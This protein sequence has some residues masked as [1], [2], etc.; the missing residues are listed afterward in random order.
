MP[1]RYMRWLLTAALVL[2][3]AQ[4]VA[5]AVFV[6]GAPLVDQPLTTGLNVVS[7]HG[8]EVVIAMTGEGTGKA[9]VHR[10]ELVLELND[11]RA[12][13][14]KLAGVGVTGV[15]AI[16]VLLMLRR[17]VGEVRDGRPF[18][19]RGA[20][21]IRTV[22]LLVLALPVWQVIH[23]ALWQGLLLSL[24]ADGGAV[25][26]TFATAQAGHENLRLMPEINLGLVFVGLILMV[27][28]EAFRAGVMLQR[29]SDEIV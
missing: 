28:G 23:A 19:P 15:L 8:R 29:D 12:A 5:A 27:I 20:A 1:A 6:V 7:D 21:R 17:F 18:T 11:W 26:S 24:M 14:L 2:T 4:F 16:T 25:V 22:G 10:G 13:V 3:A 9:V